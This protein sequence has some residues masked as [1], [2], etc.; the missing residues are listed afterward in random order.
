MNTRIGFVRTLITLMIMLMISAPLAFYMS[1]NAPEDCGKNI[2]DSLIR[3]DEHERQ[4]AGII[5]EPMLDIEEIWE[6][7]DVR[8]EAQRPLVHTMYLNEY[9]LGFDAQSNTFYCTLGENCEEWPALSLRAD[10]KERPRVVWVDDYAYDHPKDAVREGYGYQLFAYTEKEYA[11]FNIVFTGLPIVTLHVG[12][13]LSIGEEYIPVRATVFGQ[14]FD[15]IDSAAMVHTRG[16][17]FGKPIDKESYRVE[18]HA[19]NGKGTDKK[20]KVSVLGM[21]ADSDWLLL[22]NAQDPKSVCNYMAFDMWKKWNPDGAFTVLD[23]HMIELFVDDEYV[24][25]YQLMQRVSPEKEILK[26]GGNLDTDCAVKVVVEHNKSDKPIENL[27]E[28]V[29]Y[30]VEYQYEP[31]G[32]AQR[33]F[34]NLEAYIMLNENGVKRL[35][36]QQFEELARKHLSVDDLLS[37]YLFLQACILTDDNS[38]NNQYIWM[39]WEDGRYVYRLSPWDMDSGFSGRY[40]EDGKLDIKFTFAPFAASRILDLDLMG[41]REKIHAIWQE[42]RETVFSNEA[43]HDWAM[44]LE[45]RINASG[46]Y[47]RESEKWYGMAQELN[48]L[49]EVYYLE[50]QIKTIEDFFRYRWP[51]SEMKNEL[52]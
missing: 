25:L 27:M 50:N 51:V 49:E 19:T 2:L 16:G 39:S 7:E 43:L 31:N 21:E 14:G 52:Y 20:A 32:N 29:G 44:A 35:D 15:A 28:R 17:G 46:A 45:E 37:F 38:Y 5:V 40:L 3:Q 6:L 18:F 13:G 42:K 41:S 24:G 47:L 30:C 34:E 48:L 4:I 26:M 12:D 1:A 36:D 9:E 8:E 22:S 23:S 33:A 11:Y 10:G